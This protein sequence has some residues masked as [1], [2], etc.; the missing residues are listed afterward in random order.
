MPDNCSNIQARHSWRQILRTG[1][2]LLA[3]LAVMSTTSAA[4]AASDTL[5]YFMDDRGIPHFSNVPVDKRYRPFARVEVT[6]QPTG[7]PIDDDG[8][9]VP[10]AD[11]PLPS[12]EVVQVEMSQEHFPVEVQEH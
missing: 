7:Q 1:S 11:Q 12:E 8:Q 10:Y 6:Q 4:L 2:S 3:A 9:P 5:Y